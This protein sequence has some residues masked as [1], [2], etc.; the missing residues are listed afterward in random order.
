M[1]LARISD[2]EITR[3]IEKNHIENW[4]H[5]AQW[6][7]VEWVE[8]DHYTWT[9]SDIPFALFNNVFLADLQP[10][11]VE[12]AIDTALDR[13]RSRNVPLRWWIGPSTR[14]VD[15]ADH[16]ERAGFELWFK[17]LGMAIDLAILPEGELGCQNLTIEPVRD[18]DALRDWCG[19]V[20][21]IYE[22]PG[23]AGEAWFELL[24]SRGLGKERPLQHLLA[25]VDGEPVATASFFVN[26]DVAG[27][28]YVSTKP[29]YERQGIGS[30]IT[31]EA[32][33]EAKRRD[34]WTGT[35]YSSSE[36]IEMYRRLGFQRYCEVGCYRWELPVDRSSI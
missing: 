3:A 27:L 13:A 34:C 22:F 11:K 21:P 35:L 31:L 18:E 24:A 20:I 23:L 32:L 12:E 4:K 6:E 1:P 16:L 33:R 29:E 25:Y 9:L 2:V 26:G 14:P 30:A 10:E 36:A 5:W 17:G 19:V 7:K 15:L 8:E 28:S